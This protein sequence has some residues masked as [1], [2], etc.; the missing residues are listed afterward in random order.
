M[1]IGST[2]PSDLSLSF[3][4]DASG[5]A[6]RT[7]GTVCRAPSAGDTGMGFTRCSGKEMIP[8]AIFHGLLIDLSVPF[9]VSFFCKQ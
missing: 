6:R 5:L 9:F 8:A 4:T 7:G 3:S 2:V 1:C